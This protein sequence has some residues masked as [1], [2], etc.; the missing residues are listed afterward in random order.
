MFDY[1]HIK[2]FDMAYVDNPG[3]MVLFASPGMLHSGVSLDVFKRWAHDPRNM[4][5]LPGYCVPGTVGARV[6]SGEK[7][8]RP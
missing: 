8:V 4:I 1:K 6:L 2:P 3:P 5:I 7:R